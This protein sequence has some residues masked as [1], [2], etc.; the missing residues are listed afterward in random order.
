MNLVEHAPLRAA[1]RIRDEAFPVPV[2]PSIDRH[3][4]LNDILL[5]NSD[6]R[7]CIWT[8]GD[9]ETLRD[10]F[11]RQA[12]RRTRR[13]APLGILG[14][15]WRRCGQAEDAAAPGELRMREV[16][17]IHVA[18]T[19][20]VLLSR[21][22]PDGWRWLSLLS[23]ACGRL[24]RCRSI[25]IVIVATRPSVVAHGSPSTGLGGFSGRTPGASWGDDSTHMPFRS[26][27]GPGLRLAM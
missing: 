19:S 3:A 27:L 16:E 14:G 20:F 2:W 10:G 9:T 17:V 15:T 11:D 13:L 25:N 22:G 21:T 26:P 7:P 5:L 18:S 4:I 8:I 12:V 24:F 1:L 6:D 23:A